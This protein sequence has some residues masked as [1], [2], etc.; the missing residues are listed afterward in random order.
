LGRYAE[1]LEAW[2]EL[3]PAGMQL[4]PY[5]PRPLEMARRAE[6]IERY[7]ELCRERND[8][9]SYAAAMVESRAAAVRS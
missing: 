2:S 7:L 9:L 5:A 1:A 4:S 6:R 3:V 8:Y